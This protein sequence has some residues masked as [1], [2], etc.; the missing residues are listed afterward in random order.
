MLNEQQKKRA[1]EVMQE[2]LAAPDEKQKE[3][4]T[5]VKKRTFP[6][7]EE[8]KRVIKGELEP[9]LSGFLNDQIGLSEFKS[10]VDST[11][12]RNS[13]WGF[14]GI[15]GQMFFNLIVKVA[16]DLDECS[17]EIKAAI[18]IPENETI[19]SSRIKTFESYIKRLDREWVEAGNDSRGCP[20]VSSIPFFLSYFWQIQ[21]WKIWP[22]YYTNSVQTMNDLNLWS[23]S[24][25]L[26]EDYISFKKIHEELKEL[27]SNKSGKL[28]NLYMVEHVFWFKGGN[29]LTNTGGKAT[30]PIKVKGVKIDEVTIA[31]EDINLNEIQFEE[32]LEEEIESVDVALAERNIHADKSDPEVES[33][34][35]KS[36]R[37]KLV[38]Q[39]DF[40]RHFVWDKGKSSR[41]MESALLEIPLPV[42]YLAEEKDGN[43]YVI[44]GQQ[45]LTAFFSFI[46]GTFPDASEF[47]LTGLKVFTEL[48]RKSYRE[49]SEEQQDKIRYC[50]IRTI[51][52]KK[53]SE[54]D[55]KFEIFERLNT[56]SVSLNDQELR[57]CIYRGPYNEL[58][59]QLSENTNFKHLCNITRPDKRMRD[60]ELALRFAAFY[61]ATY[62]NYKPS[63][64]KFLNQDMEQ[65]QSS[66]KT[67]SLELTNAFKNSL[68]IIKSLLD[69][70]AF[71]R[72]Y[73]GTPN[74][75][76]GRW[77]PKKFNT[78][79]YDILMFSFAK[80]DKNKVYQNLD[81]IREGFINLMTSDEEFINSIE[82][83]TSS[84]QAVTTRFDKFRLMLQ[85]IIGVGQREPRCFSYELKKK[86]YDNN[87]TCTI[88][89]QK[90]QGV[91]DAA[92]DHIQQYWTGGKT[93]PENARLTHRYCNCARPRID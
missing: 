48:N 87:P 31:D 63:M 73:K 67:D 53:D 9:V 56:G 17:Q 25:N 19:A 93:I 81:S 51:T 32:P 88:C 65:N 66:S 4:S 70:R 14:K 38:I 5:E 42:V 29:P 6:V 89:K 84:V 80:Q 35:G 24:G 34:Y 71:K 41:L 30:E 37:G 78:S 77:E 44:D 3:P 52:F 61:H 83:S 76:N 11:N 59:K 39:S 1:V 54:T 23:E 79:L 7:D 33:L 68:S 2:Y 13:Y 57:N 90:I 28:F 27:F 86:L 69:K 62:L 50:P 20:K 64:R 40:Q 92:V 16:E 8:R 58:L 74:D 22:V 55:L 46:D 47:K 49:L 45:R 15:K 82:K 72:F 43:E 75:P 10:K 91:D 26:G 21:D 36:K 60:V 18:K 85:S 12:K